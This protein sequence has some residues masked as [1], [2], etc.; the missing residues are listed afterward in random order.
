MFTAIVDHPRGSYP[1]F[2]RVIEEETEKLRDARIRRCLAGL[3]GRN[4]VDI[5][6][7]TVHLVRATEDVSRRYILA[8][9]S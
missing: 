2:P 6:Q 8:E 4:R 9:E 3:Q 1:K 7:A 5:T